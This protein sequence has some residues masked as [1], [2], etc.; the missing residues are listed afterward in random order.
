M[1]HAV[2]LED[3]LGDRNPTSGAAFLQLHA[4]DADQIGEA[5]ATLG[6]GR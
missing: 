4:L 6:M 3:A 1:D 5:V 2:R